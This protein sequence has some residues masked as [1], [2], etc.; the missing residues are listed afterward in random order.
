MFKTDQR[1]I[2]LKEQYPFDVKEHRY[3]STQGVIQ[4][5]CVCMFKVYT[6]QLFNQ[7]PV[8]RGNKSIVSPSVIVV[9]SKS[10]WSIYS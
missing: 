4:V 3:T 10:F 5:C 1:D 9:L 8:A 2:V 7:P 6:V